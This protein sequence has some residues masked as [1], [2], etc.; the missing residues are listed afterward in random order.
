LSRKF[1]EKSV[2]KCG[3]VGR[4]TDLFLVFLH[5]GLDLM[6]GAVVALLLVLAVIHA[7]PIPADISSNY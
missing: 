5:A 2:L 1:C 4:R 7:I 6:P 3:E